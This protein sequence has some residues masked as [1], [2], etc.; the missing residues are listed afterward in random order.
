[1]PPLLVH[2]VV[3]SCRHALL[4][5]PLSVSLPPHLA[6]H[7]TPSDSPANV[8]SRPLPLLPRAYHAPAR[9]IMQYIMAHF[10]G[11][12][13]RSWRRQFYADLAHGVKFI[14]LYQFAPAF[15]SVAGD[16]VDADGGTYQAVLAGI[17]ELG[18]FD[19][20]VAAGS[21]LEAKVALLFSETGDIWK[22]TYGTAGA[23]KRAL[24]I[25]LKHAQLSIDVVTEADI[26]DGTLHAYSVLYIANAHIRRTA[27]AAVVGWVGA[28]G[29]AVSCAGGG[30]YDEFNHTLP[31]MMQLFG[32]ASV[33]VWTG[34]RGPTANRIDYIKQDLPFADELDTVHA[35]LPSALQPLENTTV[36]VRGRKLVWTL[37]NDGGATVMASFGS[38]NAPAILR[39]AVGPGAAIAIGFDVGLAYFAPAIPRRPVA[40]GSHDACFNHVV[41]TQFATLARAWVVAPTS[42]VLGAA[43]VH[44][45]EALVDVGVVSAA[46]VGVALPVVNWS[47]GLIQNFNVT[48]RFPVQFTH[49][50]LATGGKLT[51]SQ[52][53]SGFWSFR[54]DL[55]V[56][57]AIVL[58]V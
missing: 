1:M 49:A 37:H 54:F 32:I 56:A 20:I 30:L 47:P 45:S 51:A 58:R 40:R 18:A 39:R 46:G 8:S 15:S 22:D 28:G 24:Y 14:N 50:R 27:A 38:D 42:H 17:N 44:T 19:D 4:P 11:N 48:L 7:R 35:T 16:Y 33:D 57:D 12:T 21:V 13:P 10:P 53:T 55:D 43:P 9:P 2:Q 6:A 36:S 25:A 52:T 29:T 34:V 31:T 23:A 3:T 5:H 26:E 41:P